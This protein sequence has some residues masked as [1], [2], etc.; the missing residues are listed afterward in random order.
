[1]KGGRVFGRHFWGG[2]GPHH[3][4]TVLYRKGGSQGKAKSVER[5]GGGLIRS[6]RDFAALTDVDCLSEDTVISGEL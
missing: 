6:R 5:E 3:E 1:M 4:A 2:T